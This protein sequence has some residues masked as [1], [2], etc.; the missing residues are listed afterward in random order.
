FWESMGYPE[1]LQHRT[2]VL[3]VVAF[4]VFEWL[5]PTERFPAPGAALIFPLLCAL[6][7]GLL[8]P[9]SPAAP[10]LKEEYLVEVTHR[11]TG[12]LSMITGWGRWLELRLPSAGRLPGRI[13]PLAFTLIGLSLLFYREG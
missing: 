1:V 5:V 7:G 4:G 9:P 2:F 11:P 12:L 3:L 8:L 13:W 10:H 6:G